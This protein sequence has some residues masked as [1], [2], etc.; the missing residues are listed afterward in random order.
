MI[1][2]WILDAKMGGH[3]E[4]NQAF[5]IVLV[6][7]HE[8]PGSHEIERKIDAKRVP[9]NDQNRRRKCAEII[10]LRFWKVLEGVEFYNTF[11]RE[12]SGPNM[13]MYRT[14]SNKYYNY[15]APLVFPGPLSGPPGTS[16]GSSFRGT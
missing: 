6:V 4:Q 13:Q 8:F 2:G 16:P 5:R 14:S 1:F 15:P 9:P 10:L 7:K 3:E 12:K 11:V